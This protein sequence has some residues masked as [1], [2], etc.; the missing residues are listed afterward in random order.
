MKTLAGI[1][2]FTAV[3]A[4]I[5]EIFVGEKIPLPSGEYTLSGDDAITGV[6]ALVAGGLSLFAAI[7][8][9]LSTIAHWREHDN[10]S[11]SPDMTGVDFAEGKDAGLLYEYP[12]AQFIL[13]ISWFLITRWGFI[14]FG[15]VVAILYHDMIKL[16]LEKASG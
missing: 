11:E 4:I 6:L 9:T 3:L 8:A 7:P 15:I 2:V 10:P 5:N 14:I 13:A 12:T 16:A 1:I